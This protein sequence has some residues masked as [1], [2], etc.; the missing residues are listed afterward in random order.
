M[1]YSVS[2]VGREPACAAA[3][4][5]L[6]S[7]APLIFEEPGALEEVTDLARDWFT[8]HLTPARSAPARP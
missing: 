1:S 4:G 3:A 2:T 5:W 7:P 8:D 6:W